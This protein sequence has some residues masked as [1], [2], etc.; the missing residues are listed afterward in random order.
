VRA[1]ECVFLFTAEQSRLKNKKTRDK[2][3]ILDKHSFRACDGGIRLK[4]DVEK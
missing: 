3:K 2:K 1:A 4:D